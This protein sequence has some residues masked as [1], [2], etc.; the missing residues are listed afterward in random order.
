MSPILNIAF[1]M[2]KYHTDVLEL[3]IIMYLIIRLYLF[4]NILFNS[5]LDIV[6]VTL[7][8][9]TIRNSNLNISCVMAPLMP[10]MVQIHSVSAGYGSGKEG[11]VKAPVSP[12]KMP[13]HPISIGCRMRQIIFF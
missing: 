1:K 7:K 12:V 10:G 11:L 6:Y 9:K 13:P 8:H 5:S 3:Y 4:M 2:T